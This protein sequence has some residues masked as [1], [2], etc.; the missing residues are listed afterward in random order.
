MSEISISQNE[1]IDY[2]YTKWYHFPPINYLYKT[3]CLDSD[4]RIKIGIRIDMGRLKL[5]VYNGDL[6]AIF[7]ARFKM[8]DLRHILFRLCDTID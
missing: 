2:I 4:F 3:S 6:V 5:Y 7:Y 1:I 8:D